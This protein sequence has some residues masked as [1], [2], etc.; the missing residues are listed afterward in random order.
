MVMNRREVSESNWHDANYQKGYSTCLQ[1]GEGVVTGLNYLMSISTSL[2]M[3][4][5]VKFEVI[6]Y[7]DLLMSC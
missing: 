1:R 5:I 4:Y 3:A 7:D 2:E 6:F